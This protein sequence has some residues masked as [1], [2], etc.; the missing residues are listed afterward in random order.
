MNYAPDHRVT[1]DNRRNAL[2]TSA[3]ATLEISI[4]FFMDWLA[5]RTYDV[6][7]Q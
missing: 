4:R 3:S 1:W 6:V 7:L 2:S 5:D